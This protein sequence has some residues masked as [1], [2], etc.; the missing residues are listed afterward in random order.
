MVRTVGAAPNRQFV[1]EW[2]NMG[3]LNQNSADTGAVL[4]FE[5]VLY[6]S[7]NYIQFLYQS[8]GGPDS[9]GSTAT[10][11]F[12]NSARTQAVLASYQ[13]PILSSGF[14]LSYV[15]ANGS[16]GTASGFSIT[17]A[18]AASFLTIGS[19]TNL[20]VG[21]AAIR[22][23]GGVPASGV[24]IFGYRASGVLVSEAA[25]P[26][27]SLIRNGRIY[28]FV[29]NS[30]NTGIAIANPNPSAATISFSFTDGNGND[31]GSG[32]AI[33][34]ANGQIAKFIDQDRKSTRLNS[35]H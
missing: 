4:T 3:V 23:T 26:A 14:R 15:F 9:D 29:G 8:A 34:P 32:S 27:S 18:G 11:G 13:W 30:A 6:E 21:Y 10:I 35:S 22:Q 7:T 16:Y 33:V 28:A 12:Q 24:A 19:S 17:A 31:F 5:A 25:V 2:S 1:V 20:T